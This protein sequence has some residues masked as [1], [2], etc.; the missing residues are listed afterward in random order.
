MVD[1]LDLALGNPEKV[2]AVAAGIFRNRDQSSRAR[3]QSF[4]LFKINRAL[5]V[6]LGD[7]VVN[8]IDE[9]YIAEQR[10]PIVIKIQRDVQHVRRVAAEQRM[11]VGTVEATQ[12]RLAQ[13]PNQPASRESGW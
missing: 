6:A 1:N 13:F 2:H 8:R 4:A 10:Q 7:Q 12:V 5:P 9:R 11:Q 3:R